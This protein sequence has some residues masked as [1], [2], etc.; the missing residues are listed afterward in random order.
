MGRKNIKKFI[1]VIVFMIMIFGLSSSSVYASTQE[2]EDYYWQAVNEYYANRYGSPTHFYEETVY[3]RPGF[4]DRTT[5]SNY[6]MMKV[7]QHRTSSGVITISHYNDTVISPWVDFVPG[8]QVGISS[9]NSKT[10]T[11]SVTQTGGVELTLIK[12]ILKLSGS[13][14]V[15]KSYSSSDF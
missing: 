5:P 14:S 13:V 1:L 10:Y 7:Y 6:K 4:W 2:D 3:Y 15:E 9:G 11:H 8:V 12:D